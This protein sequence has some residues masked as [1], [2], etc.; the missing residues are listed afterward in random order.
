MTA[1]PD[2]VTAQDTRISIA[3]KGMPLMLSYTDVEQQHQGDSW[4]GCAIGFRAMQLAARELSAT[5][6]WSRQGV[7]IVSGH[8]GEGVRDA[9]E[10]ITL[11]ISQHRFALLDDTGEPGC[12]RGMRFEWWASEHG[13]TVHIRL[14]D[15][16]LPEEFF[17]M[18]DQ[19]K[20][21]PD[22]TG[23][24]EAFNQLKLSLRESIW[25][26]SLDQCFVYDSSQSPVSAHHEA[27][28]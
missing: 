10:A 24:R 12:H 9:I 21:D 25:Q 5:Q 19:V 2:I 26:R 22:D 7:Y 1:L 17:P 13:E 28:S 11:A 23:A 14:R 6:L 20:A 27:L 16:I 15:G 3:D 4:F 18:L 8:P